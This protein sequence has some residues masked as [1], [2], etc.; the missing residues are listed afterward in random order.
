MANAVIEGRQ[1]EDAEELVKEE[2]D[3]EEETTDMEQVVSE[4]AE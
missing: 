3:L 4:E 2:Q 1:G